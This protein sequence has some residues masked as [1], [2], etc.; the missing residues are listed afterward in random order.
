MNPKTNPVYKNNVPSVITNEF[1]PSFATISPFI[2]P[3][4]IP[5]LNE[6]STAIQP[7][8][9]STSKKYPTHTTAKPPIAPTERFIFPTTRASAWAKAMNMNNARVLPIVN[10]FRG[11]RKLSEVM[12]KTIK[13]IITTINKPVLPLLK[14][15]LK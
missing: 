1:I 5:I 11:V 9:S 12:L 8:C 10:I 15:D 6:T 2:N 3:A 13:I 7:G 4:K 14:I